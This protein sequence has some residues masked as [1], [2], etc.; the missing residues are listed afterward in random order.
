M[1]MKL[2]FARAKEKENYIKHQMKAYGY[3]EKKA[4][5]MWQIKC[6]LEDPHYNTET[7]EACYRRLIKL[8]QEV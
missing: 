4:T 3:S 6:L 7:G 2:A 5:K 1:S 8:A